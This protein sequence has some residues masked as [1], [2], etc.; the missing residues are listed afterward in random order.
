ME[1]FHVVI[2]RIRDKKTGF[3]EIEAR[4]ENYV[5]K[6]CDWCHGQ[7]RNGKYCPDTSTPLLLC[8]A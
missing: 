5:K 1:I 8:H 4:G 7:I 3:L 6:L 2:T